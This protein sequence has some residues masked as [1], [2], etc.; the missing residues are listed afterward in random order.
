MKEHAAGKVHGECLSEMLMTTGF[1][2][3]STGEGRG[4]IRR[5]VC[6][7]ARR[8]H[9]CCNFFRNENFGSF[10][11]YWQ[12]SGKPSDLPTY[13]NVRVLRTMRKP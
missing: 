8:W 12:L 3:S 10:S 6:D 1:R 2:P 4:Y 13:G 7:C 11:F 9:Q 5:F